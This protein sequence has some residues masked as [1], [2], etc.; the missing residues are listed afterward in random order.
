MKR[1]AF[2]MA[3]AGGAVW[4]VIARAQ[5]DSMPL[6]GFLSS[7]SPDESKPHLSGFLRGLGAFGYVEGRT[8][9][10]EY[11]WANGRYDQLRKMASELVAMKPA[12]IV[13]AGG[14]PSA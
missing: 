12:I 5:H 7:R 4:P 2:L 10:I 9:K 6:I 1:R 3:C 11:R 8:V 14:A 13:A